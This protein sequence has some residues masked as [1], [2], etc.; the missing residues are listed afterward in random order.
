MHPYSNEFYN[1]LQLLFD[2]INR[3]NRNSIIAANQIII[4]INK[5]IKE[6]HHWLKK[7]IFPTIEDEIY[8]FK[9]VKPKLISQLIYYTKIV[10][11]ESNSPI[12][13]KIKIKYL[14]K[15]L[16]Q[17]FQYSEKNKHFNQ[18]YR[19][20]SKHYDNQ[21]FTRTRGKQLNYYECHIINYD[22]RVSTPHDYCVAQIIANDLLVN[23]LEKKLAHIRSKSPTNR[24]PTLNW[25]GNKIDLIELIYALQKQKVVN[26]GNIDIKDLALSI[27]Q[28]FNM[29]L[30]DNIYRSYIDIKNRKEDKT[31]FLN[32]LSK[33]LIDDIEDEK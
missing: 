27:G 22:I 4:I 33:T 6:L 29:E 23:Y 10:E 20:G 9:Y 15:E 1:D 2:E 13:K 17:I 8:F 32:K 16:E 7:H 28:I 25:T 3:N 19:S 18:Y 24:L 11:I 5:K 26:H 14:E 30:E 21:Y 31:K 12:P